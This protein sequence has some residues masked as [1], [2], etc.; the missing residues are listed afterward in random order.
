[1]ELA[2]FHEEIEEMWMRLQ[3]AVLH[4]F[5]QLFQFASFRA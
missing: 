2:A 1:M 4:A 5:D 3:P